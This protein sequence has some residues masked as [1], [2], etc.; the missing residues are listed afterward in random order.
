MTSPDALI[1]LA[2][3]L[4]TA[5][6]LGALVTMGWIARR[7]TRFA[8][9]L[10]AAEEELALRRGRDVLALCLA[11]V[12]QA[13]ALLTADGGVPPLHLDP[14]RWMHTGMQLIDRTLNEVPP[15]APLIDALLAMRMV[16]QNG[17]SI[18]SFP[19]MTEESI[20]GRNR[21]FEHWAGSAR[22]VLED[23]DA[24]RDYAEHLPVL[25]GLAR[26]VG[27]PFK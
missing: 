19:A 18:T 27:E 22:R 4:Q 17:A 24:G 16:L 2:A 13:H 21:Q 20:R 8:A 23:Y 7:Q 12:E 10:R 15:D 1:T 25:V 3:W 9:S 26:P 6:V 14:N 5:A 11:R